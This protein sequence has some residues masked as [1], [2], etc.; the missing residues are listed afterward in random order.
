MISG[1]G[2]TLEREASETINV[3]PLKAMV[4]PFLDLESLEEM[5]IS[6][7]L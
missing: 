6:S 4:V 2:V 7:Q 3:Q 1:P 5:Y